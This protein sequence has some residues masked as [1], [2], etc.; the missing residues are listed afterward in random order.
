MNYGPLISGHLPRINIKSISSTRTSPCTYPPSLPGRKGDV[1]GRSVDYLQVG[2]VLLTLIPR[3]DGDRNRIDFFY[4]FPF[5]SSG[6]CRW[7]EVQ[8]SSD[9]ESHYDQV[10]SNNTNN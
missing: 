7:G 5:Y 9:I 8:M 10:C 6:R 4:F 3:S 2:M 1:T